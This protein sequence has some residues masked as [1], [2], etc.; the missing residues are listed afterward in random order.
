MHKST[1][2][3]TFLAKFRNGHPFEN[4]MRNSIYPIQHASMRSNGN[5]FE[6]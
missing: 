3:A 6:A 1:N 5:K 4:D 2:S